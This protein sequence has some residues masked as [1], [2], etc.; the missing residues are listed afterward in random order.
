MTKWWCARARRYF[1]SRAGIR[2]C[3]GCGARAVLAAKTTWPGCGYGQG[4]AREFG[5]RRPN[6]TFVQGGKQ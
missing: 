6:L 1:G 5:I 4:P 3:P 2:A